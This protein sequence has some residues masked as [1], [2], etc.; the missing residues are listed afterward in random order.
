MS[1]R[2]RWRQH[3]ARPQ[4]DRAN[5]APQHVSPGRTP[6]NAGLTLEGRDS[7]VFVAAFVQLR[8]C[9]RREEVTLSATSRCFCAGERVGGGRRA[10]TNSA[11]EPTDRPAR[12]CLCDIG[13]GGDSLSLRCLM[14]ALHSKFPRLAGRP[15]KSRA[16]TI[17]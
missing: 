17:I 3:W 6:N 2:R 16:S 12:N 5:R 8:H 14:C 10:E 1:T 15:G 9:G 13:S 11:A 4:F 7:Q